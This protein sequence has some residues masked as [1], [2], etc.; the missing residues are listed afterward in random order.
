MEFGDAE[1]LSLWPG[2]LDKPIGQVE[3]LR[4]GPLLRVLRLLSLASKAGLSDSKDEKIPYSFS[5]LIGQISQRGSNLPRVMWV[6]SSS[7]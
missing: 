4:G 2:S 7:G 6:V 5:D 3:K 1:I